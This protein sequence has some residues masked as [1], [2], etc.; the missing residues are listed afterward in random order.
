MIRNKRVLITGGAGFIGSL[1]TRKLLTE[2]NEVIVYDNMND[3]YLGKEHNLIEFKE[4]GNFKL[5][6][7]DI[8]DY[9][10][11]LKS[12]KNTD[13]I[14]HLAAIPG[15][16]YSFERPEYVNKVNTT[17]T[18]HVLRAAQTNGVKRVVN[19]SS[20]SVYGNNVPLPTPE[21]A[22]TNPISIYGASKLAAEH[23][24]RIFHQTYGLDV[25]SLR[26]FTAYGPGQRPDMAFH[27]FVKQIFEKKPISIYGNGKQTRDFTYVD[28]IARGTIAA[29]EKEAIGGEVFNLG[30]GK[31]IVLNDVIKI[32][33]DLLGD[34]ELQY[35]SDKMGDVKH[36][37]ADISK[38]T[39]I[40]GY[41][42]KV[43]LKMG[44]KHFID[45]YKKRYELRARRPPMGLNN[46]KEP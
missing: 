13:I 14:I 10:A 46:G 34:F 20:S 45:W 19:A 36:T 25:V 23:Y 33:Q 11:I 3:Y 6:K 15:V 28:D 38:A 40:L 43:N 42:P 41:E 21:T 16:R 26:Y 32:L 9:Q 5:V 44:L 29:A 37:L 27:K 7:N 30:S 4:K 17:G 31:R 1:V 18:I 2:N 22:N 12:S 39:K 24:C 8:L 35:E